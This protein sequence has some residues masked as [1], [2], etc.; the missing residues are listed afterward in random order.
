MGMEIMEERRQQLRQ[1][2][3]NQ[4]YIQE[5]HRGKNQEELPTETPQV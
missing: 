4:R 1:L 3:Q 5:N 2:R